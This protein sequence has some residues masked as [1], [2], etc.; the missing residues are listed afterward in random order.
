MVALAR[1]IR[2]FLRLIGKFPERASAPAQAAPAPTGGTLTIDPSTWLDVC[3][4]F[5]KQ[6]EGCRLTAY[7]DALGHVWTIGYGATGAHIVEGTIWTQAQ[8]DADLRARLSLI[9]SE[10]DESAPVVLTDDQKAA[11]VD[12]AYN[13]GIGR[14]TSSNIFTHLRDGDPASAMKELLLYDKAGTA[15][16]PGLENRRVAEA[17]LFDT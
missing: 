15:T 12:F 9:G 17:R 11:L 7:W 8:A 4:P 10:V 14:L 2:W 5:T 6:W 3:E 1:F 13:E 16:V